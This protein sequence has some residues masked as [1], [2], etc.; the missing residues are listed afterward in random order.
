[1][2][3]LP[4]RPPLWV[5]LTAHWVRRLP[6]G[7]Y[8]MMNWLCR[9]TRDRYAAPLPGSA[10][11]RFACDLRNVLARE[12][13][14]AGSYEPQE[15]ALVK[16]L[17]RPG[18]VFVDVGAHWGYFSLVAGD[19]VAQESVG[20]N[21][22]VVSIEAD[23]RI[24][25]LLEQTA[26][27]NPKLPLTPLHLAV[28]AEAGEV[29]LTGYRE[30]QDNWGISSISTA[31]SDAGEGITVSARPLDDLLDEQGIDTVALV[32]IDIEGAEGLALRGMDR[33]LRA[34]R[35]RAILME[36]HPTMLPG[37]GTTAQEVLS[38]LASAG[39]S[40]SLIDHSPQAY[41]SAVYGSTGDP[42]RFLQPWQPGDDV[43]EWPHVLCT[44]E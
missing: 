10:G 44:R 13:V 4:D 36:L 30:D 35:Y 11:A 22:R 24:F 40:I 37:F 42:A 6:A 1:M 21:G 7:R 14:F 3:N 39:F 43:G 15:T 33:G 31:A 16:H 26:A 29:Q 32:K 17:L 41:R 18:D 38:T 12:V 8:R 23:P 5:D 27:L 28:A 34:G 9:S 25:S 2:L 20:A 19:C